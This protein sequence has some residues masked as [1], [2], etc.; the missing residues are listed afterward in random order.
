[1]TRDT[2]KAIQLYREARA[3]RL[4]IERAMRVQRWINRAIYATS[5]AIV[6]IMLGLIVGPALL[7]MAAYTVNVTTAVT[8]GM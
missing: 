2:E 3:N 4:E 8:G 5:A 1:M 6:A 7:K